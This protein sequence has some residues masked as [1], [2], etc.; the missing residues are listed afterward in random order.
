MDDDLYDDELYWQDSPHH[1]NGTNPLTAGMGYAFYRHGQ[2]RQTEQLIGALSGRGGA[3]VEVHPHV[4]LDEREDIPFI[5]ALDYATQSM[6]DSW[7]DYIGQEPM[8]RQIGVY[9]KS[10]QARGDRFPHT[11]LASGFPG[12]GKTHMARL[13]AK[14]MGVRM[15]ELVPPFNIYTL[16][17]A[18]A[19]LEAGDILFI[20]EA[21]ALD[22]PLPT[23]D[24]WT[25]VGEVRV[26]D[27]LIG[28][29]GSPVRVKRLTP[30]ASGRPTYRV[31]FDD[32]VSIVADAGHRW[33]AAPRVH[34]GSGYLAPRTV[35]TQEMVDRATSWRVP[36]A[37][38]VDLPEADLPVDPYVLGQ[39]LGNGNAGQGY[40]S[41]RPDLARATM[42][43]FALAGERVTNLG[44]V[45]SLVRLSLN[46]AKPG[47]RI[48]SS[49][50]N[51]M[52]AL[53]IYTQK[54]VPG[55]Y[56]RGSI[57]QRLALVQGL[58][59][60]DGYV[61]PVTGNCTFSNT[62][63]QIVDAVMEVLRSLGYTPRKSATKATPLTRSTCFK[64]EFRGEPDRSPFRLRDTDKLRPRRHKNM[65]RVVSIEPVGSVPVRCL[66]VESDDH[67]FLAGA[68]WTVTSNC[69][70]LADNGKRGAEILLKVL[71]DHVA[72]LP[73]GEV[74]DLDD[75]TVI[76]ATTDR[77]KLPE[78]VID[79]FKVKPFFQPYSLGELAR[80]TITFASKHDALDMVD[81]DLA[82]AIAKACRGTPRITEEF[83]IAAR[84][85]HMA[86][87]RPVAAEELL[88][89]VEVEPDGL[90]RQH[91]QYLT[92]LR[93][94]FPRT[95]RDTEEIEYVVG[96]AAMQQILR[97][98]KQGLGR[99]ENFLIERGW[100][101]RTPRGRRLTA[102]GIGRA[103][104][105]IRE[106]KG[107][108]SA[109][110]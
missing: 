36:L 19:N 15:V 16:V 21:L 103:E 92:S 94:F 59:D 49:F 79:R 91:I 14:T 44:P 32:G 78:P 2:D 76:G 82:V 85:L 70:K 13:I 67:L 106:G 28:A 9:M 72:F 81:D 23:P 48:R 107:A 66:E 73:T 104:Q 57:A 109:V 87:G 62:N 90:G 88:D 108:S 11:L 34:G 84:D 101:D 46:D 8:K 51:R 5:N 12:V 53:G 110:A 83:V 3:D 22:T 38:A 26:G 37:R 41:V 58:M 97:E 68:N 54:D 96:E 1:D 35:T 50:R 61:N 27:M 65:R 7:D 64:V 98:T 31:T 10:A 99:I 80:I 93:Q 86:L 100:I 42:A 89:F 52:E 71:E 43:E 18:A 20:D 40:I 24:G 30:I 105:F 56:L 6:P 95:V 75:I 63:E 102:A 45:G 17:E 4:P 39:W 33:L 55:P 69:H 74:V 77:D 47:S 60:T 25:T 29:T